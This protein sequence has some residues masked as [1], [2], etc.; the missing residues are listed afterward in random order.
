MIVSKEYTS[1]TSDTPLQ[2][3]ESDKGFYLY[4]NGQYFETVILPA[5]TNYDDYIESNIVLPSK[6][7]NQEE[8]YEI[9]FKNASL[10][11]KQAEDTYKIILK[12]LKNVSDDE[13]LYIHF[14]FPTWESNINYV[15][16]DKINYKG[17][18]YEVIQEHTSSLAKNPEEALE[19][20]RKII[21]T[22][23]LEWEEK[24]YRLGDKVK[25][26]NHIFE[27]LLNNNIR[28]PENFPDAWKLI[29]SQ[30]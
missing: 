29:G 14:I 13:A 26:G 2:I 1:L 18:T 21:S 24:T 20:Y 25:Y 27:S 19:L 5:E 8:V 9:I 22:E 16:K 15:E 10:T 12:C 4:K 6:K 11:K 28:S 30:V 3:I 17:D 7:I 23:P